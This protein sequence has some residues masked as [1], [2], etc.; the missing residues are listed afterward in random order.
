MDWY[1]AGKPEP[2]A[3]DLAALPHYSSISMVASRKAGNS[4]AAEGDD[5]CR[6]SV[7]KFLMSRC[8]R[9][10]LNP[11]VPSHERKVGQ[12]H[13][14]RGVEPHLHGVGCGE[15]PGQRG[16]SAPCRLHSHAVPLQRLDRSDGRRVVGAQASFMADHHFDAPET[17]LSP[18]STTSMLQKRR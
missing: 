5:G 12:D 8:H 13:R 4:G 15:G 6:R 7:G 16:R 2:V 1:Y 14:L 9:R 3:N 11:G 17:T 18:V 10:P